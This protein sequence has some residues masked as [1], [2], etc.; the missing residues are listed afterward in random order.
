MVKAYLYK[1]TDYPA[2]AE[3][4]GL[5]AEEKEEARSSS[6]SSSSMAAAV[7]NAGWNIFSP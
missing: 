5:H 2:E 6:S 1:V 3:E 4:E 7:A